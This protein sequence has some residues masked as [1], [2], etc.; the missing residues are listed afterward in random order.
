MTIADRIVAL[1]QHPNPSLAERGELSTLLDRHVNTASHD[2]MDWF[3]Y[4][5]LKSEALRARI[6][7]PC[8]F[9]P[10]FKREKGRA[11][12]RTTNDV[13]ALLTL[14]RQYQEWTCACGT[15]TPPDRKTCK[16]CGKHRDAEPLTADHRIR[17]CLGLSANLSQ[18]ET[19][20]CRLCDD[21]RLRG[22]VNLC[23]TE[24]QRHATYKLKLA[25][26]QE[27][28]YAL[29]TTP[30]EHK[31]FFLADEGYWIGS[32]DLRGADGWTIAAECAAAGDDA[33]LADL[34]AD[35][36]PA[37]AV[38]LLYKYGAEVNDWPR[39]KVRARVGD[40]RDPAWLYPAAKRVIW[41][42]C[43]TDKHEVLTPYGWQPLARLPHGWPIVT[44][45]SGK[46]RWSVP[47]RVI[48][49]RYSGKLYRFVGNAFDLET[50]EEHRMPYTVGDGFKV[51]PAHELFLH[52]SASL[53]LSGKWVEGRPEPLARLIAAIQADGSY[54]KR[55]LS[56]TLRKDR[57][58]KRLKWLLDQ[59][60]IDYTERCYITKREGVKEYVIRCHT[61]PLVPKKAGPWLLEWDGESLAAY[62]DEAVHWDGCTQGCL[63]TLSSADKEHLMWMGVVQ[64]LTGNGFVYQGEWP[65]ASGHT[66]HRL[67]LNRRAYADYA[68]MKT[69]KRTVTN[70]A[71]HCV[72]TQD[73]FF[74][75]RHK[76]KI[77]VTGNCYG[78]GDM[79]VS[80]QILKESYKDTGEPLY[81][82]P[83]ICRSLQDLT[84]LRYRGIV[85]RQNLIKS[86]LARDGVITAP[87]GS[88]RVFFGRKDDAGTQR[89][90]FAYT[91]QVM[92][93]YCTELAWRAMWY[94]PENVGPGGER[95]CQPLLLVHDSIVFQWPKE[96]TDWVKASIPAW[97]NNEVNIAGVK[98]V[99]PYAGGYGRSWGEETEG[100]L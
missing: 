51:C 75:V 80:V 94:D 87:N 72:T 38:A 93:T 70:C 34:R 32:V 62:A 84:R 71:V 97:F 83:R 50:T 79:A 13:E 44:W 55:S 24:T 3:L 78:A 16:G 36:K 23:G 42:T 89:E 56:F 66:C 45:N 17:L 21:E 10:I 69:L 90:A 68:S 5:R 73:G 12:T 29:H 31:R 20:E 100:T 4:A 96:R 18:L 99:V 15:R 64:R 57:K 14:F 28:G 39:E 47:E 59:A 98:L 67:S 61:A 8:G 92:T 48:H 76:D 41:G 54:H 74:L 6:P 43:L 35:V 49:Q 7:F 63:R 53:P 52:P 86:A 60:G 30:A 81:V 26:K 40:A 46:F 85:W 27:Y 19:A 58:R 2:Q 65:T 1:A 82:E 88:Q 11:T 91:P 37:V 95:I 22:S 33:M 9:K 77:M 25:P